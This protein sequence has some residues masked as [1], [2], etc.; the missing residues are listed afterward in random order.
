M[1]ELDH[2]AKLALRADPLGVLGHALRGVTAA[3]PLEK[4]MI[5]AVR[6]VDGTYTA[7]VD[8][9]EVVVHVE[10]EAE[11]SSS[12]AA[13]AVRTGC[14][15]HALT[16]LRVRVAVFYLHPAKDGRK[17]PERHRL[18]VGEEPPTLRVLSA[19]IWELEPEAV[20][21]A[22]GLVPFVGLTHDA[23]L[24]HIRRA[25]DRIGAEP[26]L[27]ERTRDQLV[28]ATH[29]LGSHRFPSSQL[30]AIIPEEVLMQSP[31]YQ[32]IVARSFRR[33]AR[34]GLE[35]RFGSIPDDLR[36]PLELA[37]SDAL[38]Q[39]NLA[40]MSREDDAVLLARV[41]TI[42]GVEP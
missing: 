37:G 9:E 2:G 27:D 42:L 12:S 40:L 6:T 13:R 5:S 23:S 8:G 7:T 26:G 14:L 28:V 1:G 10:F 36:A 19:P 25:V 29:L 31:A 18:P 21:H 34:K 24:G 32:E 15:L 4:E 39:V 22:L 20:L 35:S 3:K 11:P 16:E 17:P 41:R 33:T 38:E 30:A